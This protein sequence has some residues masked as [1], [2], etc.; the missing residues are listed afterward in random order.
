MYA[1]RHHRSPAVDPR[2][3]GIAVA[4]NGA[5]VAALMLASPVLDIVHRGHPLTIIDVPIQ[6][7]PE[8]LPPPKP[9]EHPQ[10]QHQRLSTP[11][12]RIDTLADP[13]S[14]ITHDDPTPISPTPIGP[15]PTTLPEPTATPVL[16]TVGPE[17]DP[18]HRSDLQ[19]AYPASELRAE[20]EG[21]VAVRVLV[22]VDGR[23]HEVQQV[24]ATSDAFFRAT[25]DRALAHWR[26]RPA[27]RGGVP[28][29]AWRTMTIRFVIPR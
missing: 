22:G 27:T 13:N 18:A 17:I 12:P 5:I 9:V 20:R 2:S 14:P 21:L 15:G 11:L 1:D 8:P 26:F 7:D 19:P 3:L 10:S 6:P 16:V 29:E 4:L 23:V 28:I 24:S 25:Q